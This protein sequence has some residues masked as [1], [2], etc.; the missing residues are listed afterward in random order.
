MIRTKSEGMELRYPNTN[1]GQGIAAHVNY[2]NDGGTG[3]NFVLEVHVPD[4]DLLTANLEDAQKNIVE[5]VGESVAD[6]FSKIGI[7]DT[8]KGE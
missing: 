2:R 3:M 5:F 1:G 8:G 6:I 7:A 4:P